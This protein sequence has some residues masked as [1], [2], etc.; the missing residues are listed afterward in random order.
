ML[1]KYTRESEFSKTITRPVKK[2]FLTPSK[3]D[4]HKSL[5]ERQKLMR[6]DMR[7]P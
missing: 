5:E 4:E 7:D 6:N 3:V 2:L 1:Y